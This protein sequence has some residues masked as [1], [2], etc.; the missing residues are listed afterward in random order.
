MGWGILASLGGAAITAASSA[1]NNWQNIQYQERTN[2]KNESLMRESWA[3]DDTA[4]TRRVKDLENSGLNPTLAAGSAAGNSGPIQLHAPEVRENPA[5]KA[6]ITAN[7]AADLQTK[8]AQRDVLQNQARGIDLD[9][10]LKSGTL[11]SQIS[12]AVNN[13]RYS[14]ETL[15]SRIKEMDS[16]AISEASKATWSYLYESESGYGKMYQTKISQI[17]AELKANTL[18]VARQ[19]GLTP[20]AAQLLNLMAQTTLNQAN[21]SMV[22]QN[23]KFWSDLG[24]SPVVG[25]S[26]MN[27]I[28]SILKT[29]GR[30]R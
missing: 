7:A 15:A 9:N 27:G 17:E 6:I 8:M 13:A 30:T 25:N 2:S 21:A 22:S 26:V 1:W 19:Y 3:R 12:V 11:E 23:A 28:D 14:I 24:I 18:D 20:E 4:V 10:R 16:K 5:E 29:I